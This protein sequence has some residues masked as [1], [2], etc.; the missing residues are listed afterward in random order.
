MVFQRDSDHPLNVQA[1]KTTGIFLVCKAVVILQNTFQGWNP[2]KP[3][4]ARVWQGVAPGLRTGE[5]LT[6]I[7]EELL[8]AYRRASGNLGAILLS[9]A[10]T[11]CTEF[12]LVSRWE[13]ASFLDS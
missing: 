7:R 5:H 3:M 12:F 2:D 10:R 4:I 6:Y 8:G 13:S 11:G 9:R 1:P